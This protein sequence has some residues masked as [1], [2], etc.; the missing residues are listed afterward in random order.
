[1]NK[2]MQEIFEYNP[3]DIDNKYM[4]TEGWKK[5]LNKSGKET[6]LPNIGQKS[7]KQLFTILSF[8]VWYD[9]FKMNI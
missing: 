5:G 6:I 3:A 8:A 1:M 4:S 9:V 2:E 7:Q